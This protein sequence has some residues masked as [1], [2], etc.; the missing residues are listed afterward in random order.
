MFVLMTTVRVILAFKCDT[1]F[2]H[3]KYFRI[4]DVETYG[5]KVEEQLQDR[6][7]DIASLERKYVHFS[8]VLA[9]PN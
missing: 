1:V 7:K 8:Q 6:E 9:N 5:Q 2:V 3:T 4:K